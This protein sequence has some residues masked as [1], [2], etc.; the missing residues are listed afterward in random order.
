MKA[1]TI[2][3]DLVEFLGNHPGVVA[4]VHSVFPHAVN[5]LVCDDDLITITNQNDLPPM[6]LIV[7]SHGSFTHLLKAGDE[8]VLDVEQL[9]VT[10]GA[11]CINLRGAQGWENR[12]SMNLVPRSSDEVAQVYH[13]LISWLAEQPALGLLPLLPRL[14]NLTT[15]AKQLDDNLYS[16]F[17]AN[18]LEAF[19]NAIFSSN[20]E[21]ALKLTDRLVGFGM[22]STP[23]CDDFL[24]AYL[25]VFKIAEAANPACF[26]WVSEFNGAIANKAKQ[27]TT[28]ISANMLRHAGNG[29]I[30]RSHQRLIQTCLFNDINDLVHSASQV[31]QYGATSGG[32]FLLGLVCA[33]E[34]YRNI[35][36]DFPM[37]GERAWVESKQP[38]PVPII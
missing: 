14:A 25:V 32:D 10:K 20:W 18:D 29:K 35:M 26:P 38:Q 28:L 21:L 11:F 23:S 31:M 24:A 9:T 22:G 7:E 1:L 19:V 2:A 36:T 3:V 6:G 37:K 12:S 27:R 30:S 13:Q 5:L 4:T 34:W 17:I 33:I 8:V 16:R 15:N